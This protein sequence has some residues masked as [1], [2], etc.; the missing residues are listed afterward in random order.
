MAAT[1]TSVHWC[2]PEVKRK[3]RKEKRYEIERHVEASW[4]ENQSRLEKLPSLL[5]N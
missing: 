3:E 5:E 4:E 1:T 2:A